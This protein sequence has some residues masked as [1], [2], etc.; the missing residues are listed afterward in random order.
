MRSHAIA[1]TPLRRFA[2]LGTRGSVEVDDHVVRVR[3]GV[4]FHADIPRSAVVAARVVEPPRWAGVGVHAV[5]DGWIVNSAFGKVA[6]VR[7]HEPVPARTVGIAIHPRR[8]LLGVQDPD[9]LVA[10]LGW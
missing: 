6:E 10:D 1:T 5:R 2:L 8:L 9:A 7:F 4:L 3:A